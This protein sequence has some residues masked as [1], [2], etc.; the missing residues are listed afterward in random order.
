MW[1]LLWCKVAFIVV[2]NSRGAQGAVRASAKNPLSPGIAWSGA[3]PSPPHAGAR[4]CLAP[5]AA[6]ALP[7]RGA[8]PLC[9]ARGAAPLCL[10]RG[11]APLT[12]QAEAHS[13]TTAMQARAASTAGEAARAPRPAAL[14]DPAQARGMARG[15][16]AQ[17]RELGR[18]RDRVAGQR[19]PGGKRRT[20]ASG[21]DAAAK[22]RKARTAACGEGEGAGRPL[23]NAAPMPDY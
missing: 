19:A 16:R 4:L 12:R 20:R 3:G 22:P 9:L 14:R 17:W 5:D 13:T 8:A 21:Q 2:S 6:A 18:R 1:R 15:S 23:P 10:A 11:A 7:A